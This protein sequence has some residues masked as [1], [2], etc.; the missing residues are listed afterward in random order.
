MK[1]NVIS[2]VKDR[3]K[4]TRMPNLIRTIGIHSEVVLELSVHLGNGRS[5]PSA[6]MQLLLLELVCRAR[7]QND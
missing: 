2:E 6:S 5:D 4:I 1:P 3:K 7:K